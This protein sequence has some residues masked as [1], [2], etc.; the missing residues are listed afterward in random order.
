MAI[1]PGTCAWTDP[2]L[3]ETW[4][5]REAR[6]AEALLRYYAERFDTVE[7]NA[8]YYGLPSRRNA[9]LWA[10]R[11]P[12]GFTF[13]VKAFGLMTGHR[14]APE[15]LPEDLR[16]GIREL[17]PRGNVVP[18]DGL[19]GRVFARFREELEPLREAGRLGG[20]LLQ[21]PPGFAPGPASLAAIEEAQSLL[22]DDRLLIEF[23]RR[24]WLEGEQREET[25]R[26]LEERGLTYVCVD[27]PAVTST[28]VLPTVV[29]ATS[30]VGYVRFH[31]RNA[32]T[33]NRAAAASASERFDHA[34]SEDELREWVEPLRALSDATATTF[35]M[36][37]TNNL[38]QGPRNAGRLRHL[39][40]PQAAGVLR[41]IGAGCPLVV[42]DGRDSGLCE[43]FGKKSSAAV[44]ARHQRGA[45]VAIGRAAARDQNNCWKR[46]VTGRPLDCSVHLNAVEL[47]GHIERSRHAPHPCMGRRLASRSLNRRIRGPAWRCSRASRQVRLA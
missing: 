21:Y 47:P 5:P 15:Q 33:W 2:G 20:I 3:L 19:V 35:A 34:Y 42:P 46:S 40:Q 18:D 7:V 17:T 39:W 30:D 6:T 24:E 10:R 31:G 13:H 4:Y 28:N 43:R 22:P 12:P 29:A 38:D 23:R 25:L 36:F 11:T 45:P 32:A 27:A 16:S 37:N 44:G 26:F 14:V 9:E 1:R 41:G 8:T